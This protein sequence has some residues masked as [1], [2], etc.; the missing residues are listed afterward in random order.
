M[1]ISCTNSTVNYIMY[2]CTVICNIHNVSTRQTDRLV[3]RVPHLDGP[4]EGGTG[5]LV[6][7]LGVEYNHHHIVGVTL[8]HLTALP[9]LI[10]VPQLDQ[11][12]IWG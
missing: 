10:P 12:V 7:V 9:L 6:V 1:Y 8:K 4:V 3:E 11:H 2:T 5:K